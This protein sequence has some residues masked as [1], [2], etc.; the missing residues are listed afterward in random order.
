[1]C[2]FGPRRYGLCALALF[3]LV[4]CGGNRAAVKGKVTFN[5]EP[6]ESGNIAFVPA[7]DGP[8]ASGEISGGT[9]SIDADHGPGPGK[10]KVEVYWNK[11][12]GKKV[13][14]PGDTEVKMDETRQI[15]PFKF[16]AQSELTADVKSGSNT[17]D[18]DLKGEPLKAG[19]TKPGKVQ[20]AGD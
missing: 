1:M 18:F 14:T 10:H 4:G 2:Y 12:T 20:A 17:F 3:L 7:G 13:G 11:K 19:A 15:I 8:R 5:G 9:Y 6:V 16:N